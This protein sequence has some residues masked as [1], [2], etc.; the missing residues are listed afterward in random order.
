MRQDELLV[1][2]AELIL[3][4]VSQVPTAHTELEH[5]LL[6]H[7]SNAMNRI[8]P[9]GHS[10]IQSPLEN[11]QGQTYAPSLP[12]AHS[13]NRPDEF[14]LTVAAARNCRCCQDILA[15]P[16]GFE[17]NA[18]MGRIQIISSLRQALQSS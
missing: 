8:R 16:T 2:A 7:W 4:E 5:R 3:E 10:A 17:E 11:E 6:I 12:A 18:P 14:D 9:Q 15:R 1:I 13:V